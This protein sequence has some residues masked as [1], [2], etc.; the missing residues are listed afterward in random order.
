MG[1]SRTDIA[2]PTRLAVGLVVALSGLWFGFSWYRDAFG[3][4]QAREDQSLLYVDPL[5][6]DIG[7]QWSQD[8]FKWQFTMHNKGDTAVGI[9]GF[10]VS[11]RCTTLTPHKMSISPHSS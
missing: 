1:S 5:Q 7:D 6:L 4:S 9:R 11:C 8:R 10:L 3:T 2:K